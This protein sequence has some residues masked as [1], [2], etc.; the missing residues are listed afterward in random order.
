MSG[1]VLVVLASGRGSNLQAILQAIEEGRLD[2]TVAAVFSDRQDAGALAVAR[3]RGIESA[4]IDP[5]AYGDKAGYEHA[6]MER[7][8]AVQ[9]HCLA[10]AGYMRMLSPWFVEQADCPIVNIHPSLLPAFAGLDPHGQAIESGV[11]YSGCTVHF[12]D[13]GMDTG[14]IIMQRVAPVKQD[15]TR[16]TLASRILEQEHILFPKVLNLMARG[17]ILRQNR[18]VIILEEEGLD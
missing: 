2:A 3:S 5:E 10:L 15:D 11:R 7:I 6:L 1:Y 13:E 18:K 12:V 8:R 9:P 17:L 4:W 16:D 14:P